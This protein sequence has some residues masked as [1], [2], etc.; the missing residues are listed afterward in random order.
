M[1]RHGP[2]L[3]PRFSRSKYMWLID[4]LE[5]KV[6]KE[7]EIAQS[8]LKGM[9]WD[10]IAAGDFHC[11]IYGGK[12]T[13]SIVGIGKI[14]RDSYWRVNPSGFQ[15]KVESRQLGIKD[16]LDIF[17][18]GENV[19]KVIEFLLRE[20]SKSLSLKGQVTPIN[21]YIHNGLE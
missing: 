17:S 9:R 2:S 4:L 10:S 21:L 11:A 16:I 13:I 1:L 18:S 6:A 3:V 19:L 7:L 12:Q 5:G 14:F 8:L 15:M 20:D